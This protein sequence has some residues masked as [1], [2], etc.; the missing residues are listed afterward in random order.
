LKKRRNEKKKNK[1]RK[2]GKEK[3]R[4]ERGKVKGREERR[5]GTYYQD[6]F[7]SITFGYDC[8]R[9]VSISVGSLTF[10][11]VTLCALT[12]DMEPSAALTRNFILSG[13]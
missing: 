11:T 2:E 3:G 12:V 13:N 1:D 5:G 10:L 7:S 8:I 9:D 6:P 4:E